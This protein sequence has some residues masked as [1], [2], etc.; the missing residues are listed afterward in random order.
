M[1]MNFTR[2]MVLLEGFYKLISKGE[3]THIAVS[4]IIVNGLKYQRVMAG[5]Y[6]LALC[7]QVE[8]K[9]ASE[10]YPICT[11]CRR[12]VYGMYSY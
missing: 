11:F 9:R 8:L 12:C 1:W 10:F 5:C 2:N 3:H 4:N 7:L 6:Y